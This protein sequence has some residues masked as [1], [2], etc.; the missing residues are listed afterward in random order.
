MKKIFI[1]LITTLL[2]TSCVVM[3]EDDLKQ[4]REYSGTWSDIVENT[5]YSKTEKRIV[6]TS[7]SYAVYLDTTNKLTDT[8][9]TV[10]ME[11]GNLS[12]YDASTIVLTQTYIYETSTHSLTKITPSFQGNHYISWELNLNA[13]IIVDSSIEPTHQNVSGTFIK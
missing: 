3:L 1:T 10:E 7:D 12:E 11:R 5:D 8:V 9:S 13:L 4:E 2:L 6:L